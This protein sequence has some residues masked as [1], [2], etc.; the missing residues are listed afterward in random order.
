MADAIAYGDA[1]VAAGLIK[2]N[3]LRTGSGSGG[4]RGGRRGGRGGKGRA[5]KY[6][7]TKNM[8]TTSSSGTS[9]SLRKI[10]KK[11]MQAKS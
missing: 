5:S 6:D 1:L 3:K 9:D 11:A 7:Y 10:L 4:R 2:K 8:F